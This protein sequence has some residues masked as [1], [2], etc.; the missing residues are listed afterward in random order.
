MKTSWIAPAIAGCLLCLGLGLIACFTVP[1]WDPADLS[2][3][4]RDPSHVEI[5]E[6]AGIMDAREPE[7]PSTPAESRRPGLHGRAGE[8]RR[9]CRLPVFS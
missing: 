6:E 4:G 7:I 1:Q 5:V 2:F 3:G 9:P 8:S